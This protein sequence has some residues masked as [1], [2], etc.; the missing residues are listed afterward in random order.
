MLIIS[1][2]YLTLIIRNKKNKNLTD[3]EVV[4]QEPPQHSENLRPRTDHRI[5]GSP[6]R[7]SVSGPYYSSFTGHYFARNSG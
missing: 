2:L 7:D 5:Y 1:S 4:N 6:A 3:M